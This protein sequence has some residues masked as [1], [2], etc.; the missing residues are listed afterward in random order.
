MESFEF[1][2]EDLSYAVVEEIILNHYECGYPQSSNFNELEIGVHSNLF[3][4]GETKDIR[5]TSIVGKK[6]DGG[7]KV[8]IKP[9]RIS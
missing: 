9:E 3:I 7:Y 4:Q 2:T 5:F 1:E 6:V 8:T